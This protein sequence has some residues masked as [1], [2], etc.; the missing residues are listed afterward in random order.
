[1]CM[2]AQLVYISSLCAMIEHMDEDSLFAAAVK[3]LRETRGL[4]QA[5]LAERLREL[6]NANFHPTTIGRIESGARGVRL[7]EARAIA[8]ALDSNVSD[9]V[10]PEG[11]MKLVDEVRETLQELRTVEGQVWGGIDRI[12]GL[13]DSLRYI[14]HRIESNEDGLLDELPDEKRETIGGLVWNIN[15][16]LNSPSL[17]ALLHLEVP[18]AADDESAS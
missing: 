11:Y 7:A 9:M 5:Q 15:R 1:M 8:V 17:R 6:G 14:V 10:Q 12:G 2:L 3:R 18:E 13:V 4:S 16:R